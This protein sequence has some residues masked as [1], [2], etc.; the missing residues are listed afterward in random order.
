MAHPQI[1]QPAVCSAQV[2]FLEDGR[3]EGGGA[4]RR[5]RGGRDLNANG[6]LLFER[7]GEKTGGV[8]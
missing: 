7:R 3:G 6:A 8:E 4:A 2:L 5:W 1:Q